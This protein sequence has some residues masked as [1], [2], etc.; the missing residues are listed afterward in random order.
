[1]KTKLAFFMLLGSR[2]EESQGD[3]ISISHYKSKIG[4]NETG[5]KLGS[6]SL[7]L[8]HQLNSQGR[9]TEALSS[10]FTSFVTKFKLLIISKA[11]PVSF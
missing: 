6:F 5:G 8:F 10:R 7:P 11:L 4:K 2:A 3:S 1:M 9:K